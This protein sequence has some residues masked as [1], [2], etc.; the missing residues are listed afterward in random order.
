ML[1]ILIPCYNYDCSALVQ[2]LYRQTKLLPYP[3]EILVADDASSMD[4]SQLEN[5]IN[6]LEN[7]R[8]LRMEYN[9]GRAVIRNYLAGISRYEWL[10]FLDCDAAIINSN[11][12]ACYMEATSGYDVVCGGLKYRRPLPSYDLSLRYYYGISAEERTAEMRNKT[13]YDKFTTFSFLIK[14]EVFQQI[15]FDESFYKYGHEDSVFGTE[16]EKRK[17]KILHIDNPLYH[18]GLE[19]NDN[20]LRKT[21]ISIENL[22]A[23]PAASK[24]KSRLMYTYKKIKSIKLSPVVRLVFIILRKPLSLHLTGKHPRMRLFAFYKLGYLCYIVK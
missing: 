16:L 22:I 4:I 9:S 21:E 11:F 3:V 10:L 8:F 5:K 12:L 14:R 18:E 23:L 19:T 2:E 17:I 7:C 15:R 13:P 24:V 1:S 6:A 20:F